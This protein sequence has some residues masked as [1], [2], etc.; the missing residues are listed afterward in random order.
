MLRK[1]SVVF[2]FIFLTVGASAATL[3]GQ[4]PQEW[5]SGHPVA[6]KDN[7][8]WKLKAVPVE[9]VQALPVLVI[10]YSSNGVSEEKTVEIKI[11]GFSF[12]PA[13]VAVPV[14]QKI[15][16]NNATEQSF[17]CLVNGTKTARLDP[18]LPGKK[19]QV[20]LTEKG[21]WQIS[22]PPYDF[23]QL[24]IFSGDIAYS[25][26]LDNNGSFKFGDVR[27]GQYTLK[28]MMGEKLLGE[29]VINVANQSVFVD[30]RSEAQKQKE[31]PAT[32][33]KTTEK[34]LT[35]PPPPMEPP[36]KPVAEKP[37]PEKQPA[38]KTQEGK[39]VEKPAPAAKPPAESQESSEP[40]IE[41]EEE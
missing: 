8:F 19:Q 29:R 30:F 24:T 31:P 20:T 33:A 22:C 32:T 9:Q 18:F 25:T 40:E 16:F 41:V 38:H 11:E 7:F 15:I 37:A 17:N 10:L 28:V 3:S 13:L 1:L 35:A 34:Q 26:W 5:L 2:S 39:P 14:E 12:S 36:A 27:P 21:L 23:M 6:G 4:V